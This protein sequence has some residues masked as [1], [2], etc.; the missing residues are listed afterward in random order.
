MKFQ[1]ISK[2]NIRNGS[3][4]IWVRDYGEHLT[5][6][7][8][9]V[10]VKEHPTQDD[11]DY[12]IFGKGS[13]N[14][15]KAKIAKEL[16][17]RALLGWINPTM[18]TGIALKTEK[19]RVNDLDFFI[20][21][22]IEERESLLPYKNNVFILPLVE[23][24]FK[25]DKVHSS[26]E[27]ITLGYHGNAHHLE[28]FFPHVTEAIEKLSEEVS[29][30]MIAIHTPVADWEWIKGKP[31]IELEQIDWNLETVEE[32]LLQCDIGLVPGITPVDEN[33]QNQ[34]FKKT[35]SIQKND[36]I[37]YDTDYLLR[38]KNKS[39]AGRS[40]VFH[41]LNIPVVAAFMPSHFHIL[42]NPESGYLAHSKEGW[43]SGLR[44]LALCH[45]K[46][47]RMAKSAKVEFNRLY[48]PMDWLNQMLFNLNHLNN[49]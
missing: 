4:R 49:Q 18:D 12:V 23:T 14:S 10:G 46:R 25:R 40:F 32:N 38:F 20:V 26:K 42:G 29:L 43:Y 41:Q 11:V 36:F 47:E 45:K 5:Q 16:N 9:Q 15:K 2:Y 48:D 37:G 3:D 28:E 24:M 31:N 17:P 7:G 39:N 8:H 35:K 13:F 30:K 19:K 34:V 1:F 44:D 6:I 33:I 22:S 21:G 27:K